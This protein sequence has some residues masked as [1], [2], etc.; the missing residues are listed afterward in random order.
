MN[1]YIRILSTDFD[2]VLPLQSEML[3]APIRNKVD[4]ITLTA[5]PRYLIKIV[6]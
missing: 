2:D 3:S 4:H 5:L 6:P 1:E